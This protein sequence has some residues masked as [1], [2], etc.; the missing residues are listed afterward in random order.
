MKKKKIAFY[1][2]GNFARVLRHCTEYLEEFELHAFCPN[3]KAY[4]ICIQDGRFQ[5]VEYLFESL[6]DVF[7]SISEDELAKTYPE[8]NISRI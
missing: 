8:I 7:N 4:D 3:K 5:K 6:N 1:M 2:C